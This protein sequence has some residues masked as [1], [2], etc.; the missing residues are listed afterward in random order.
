MC[1]ESEEVRHLRLDCG[2]LDG[3]YNSDLMALGELPA[4]SY[5]VPDDSISRSNRVERNWCYSYF[6]AHQN[7][8]A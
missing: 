1:I 3:L 6:R 8:S 2:H 5:F 7:G 4:T